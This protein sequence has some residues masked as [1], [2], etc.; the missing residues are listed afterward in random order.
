MQ[1][2][3][4]TTA[5]PTALSNVKSTLPNTVDVALADDVAQDIKDGKAGLNPTLT[6]KQKHNAAA[7]QKISSKL[8]TQSIS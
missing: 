8:M 4:G 3:D 6:D 1:N 7:K 5:T 2:A